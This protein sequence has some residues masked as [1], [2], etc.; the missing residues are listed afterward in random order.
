M[1][2]TRSVYNEIINGCPRS[3]IEAGGILG[4]EHG[5]IM[6]AAFDSTGGEYGKY[7]PNTDYLNCTISNWQ[8]EQIDFAGIFHSHY[9]VGELLSGSD[10]EY[11]KTIMNAL[12]N[13][14]SELY[15]PVVI[16]DKKIVS[17]KAEI[18]DGDVV[19]KKDK[20]ILIY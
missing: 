10:V 6:Y 16:P 9:P 7:A 14:C 3:P 17:Y 15:F 12:K 2:I 19:I 20:I 18:I 11:I 1:K 13:A 4:A 8:G 5:V